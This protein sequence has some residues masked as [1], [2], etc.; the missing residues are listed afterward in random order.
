MISSSFWFKGEQENLLSKLTDLYYI[1]AYV[2]SCAKQSRN[3]ESYLAWESLLGG[4][5]SRNLETLKLGYNMKLEYNHIKNIC[6]Y[7][8]Q[9]QLGHGV[10]S[11]LVQK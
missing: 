9:C 11:L 8:V 7:N 2:V 5:G 6:I 3:L 4:V 10:S 1:G